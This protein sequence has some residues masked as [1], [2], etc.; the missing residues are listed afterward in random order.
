MITRSSGILMPVFSLP[1][2]YGIGNFGDEAYRFV[3]FL[4]SS[5]QTWWQILP[6]GPTSY[7]DSPYQSFSTFAGNPYFVDPDALIDEGLLTKEE[8]LSFDWGSDPHRIDYEKIYLSRNDLLRKAFERDPNARTKIDEFKNANPWVEDFAMFMALKKKFGMKSWIEWPDR[9]IRVREPSAISRA[10]EELREDI[11]LGI[12]IQYLFDMQWSKLK[13]YAND[14][15]IKIFGDLPIY[16][17]L[18]SSDVWADPDSFL[19]DSDHIPEKVAGVPP[20]A[21]SDEG[22]LWGNPLYN[23][24]RM[25]QDGYGWWIRRI[26][27]AAKWYD[28]IRIDHFRGFDSYWAVPY[29]A[30]TAMTGEWVKGP[31]LKFINTM[32]SWFYKVDFIAEDLGILTDSVRDLL[33][34]SKLPGMKVLEFAFDPGTNSDYLPHNHTENSICY[35]GTHDNDTILGWIKSSPKENIRFAKKYLGVK[36]NADLSDALIRAGMSSVSKVFI[37]QMQD[38]LHLGPEA[39]INTPSTLGL[40]WG[41]RADKGYLTKPLSSRIRSL[42]ET[43]GRYFPKEK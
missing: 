8:V 34:D 20:D 19:L 29:G 13:K 14:L 9:D 35:V 39:R 5:G 37:C 17:A 21:F 28:S 36:T 16:V 30:T 22:Q 15:G 2:P 27:R 23:W 12:Y 42:S 43:Y 25:E 18:D 3:D 10:K 38:Y 4:A 32:T 33:R 11:D 31:G 40:N 7:G 6:L 1:S 26:E 24:S 41:W